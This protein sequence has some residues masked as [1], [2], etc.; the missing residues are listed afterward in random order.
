M[1]KRLLIT[2]PFS[3][4]PELLDEIKLKFEVFYEY[5]PSKDQVKKLIKDFQPH[6]WIPKPCNEYLIDEELFKL[7]SSRN[8]SYTIDRYESYRR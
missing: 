7:S 2:A 8:H 3:F 6:A 4:I 1:K 5:Q